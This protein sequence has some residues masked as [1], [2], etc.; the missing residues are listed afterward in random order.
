MKIIK[1]FLLF[2]LVVIL[3]ITG[4]AF[5]I[6]TYYGD[7]IKTLVIDNLNKQLKTEVS[8]R[9]AEF[10]VWENFPQA[11]VVFS[12]VVIYA[13][14]SKNDTLLAAKKLSAQF[15]LI[16]LYHENYKL[17]G[18]GIE[19]GQCKMLTDSEGKPN[20]I[21][22]NESDSSTNTSFS[23]ELEKVSI[24]E[25]EFFYL[26]YSTNIALGFLIEDLGLK[27]NF[28]DA[29]FEMDLKSS[30]KHAN[31]QV[32]ET[33]V[34]SERNLLLKVNGN[35]DQ[36]GE[37]LNFRQ[38]S[39]GIDD[40]TVGVSGQLFYGKESSINVELSSKDTDL[41][42]AIALLPYSLREKLKRFNIK[43]K[44][45]FNG[46]ITGAINS[47]VSPSYS[48]QFLIDNG[49]FKDK[50]SDLKFSNTSLKGSI[51]NG[52][53]K[54]VE[55]TT[56]TLTDFKTQLKNSKLN[57]QLTIENFKQPFYDFTGNLGFELQE[58]IHFLQL[59]EISKPSGSMRAEL[60]M[61]G[62]MSS[63]DEY[64]LKDWKKASVEGKVTLSGVG[65]KYEGHP[66]IVS[67]G[68]GVMSFNNNS[69]N[70][71]KLSVNIDRSQLEI[72][73]KFNNLIG[74]LINNQEALFVDAKLYSPR[75]NLA[76][77]LAS[78][79]KAAKNETT[80]QLQISPRITFYLDT[81]IDELQFNQFNLKT[82]GGNVV[83]KNSGIDA[84]GITFNSQEGQFH[85]DLFIREVRDKLTIAAI[86]DLQ[87]ID[88]Q[89]TF[90]SFNNFGQ[91]TLQSDHISGIANA[92]INFSST[93]SKN[94][95]VDLNSIA[96]DITFNIDKGRLRNF[97]PLES[98]SAFIELDE[99]RDVTF[100][101]L[102]NQI[103]IKES[104]ITI[105]RFNIFS[106]AL[107]VSLAG[108][109]TFENIIDYRVTLLLSEVLGRKAKKSKSYREANSEFG[110][111]EDDGLGKT[112]LFLKMTGSVDQPKIAYDTK[113]L[114]T[115]LQ[116]K[117]SKEKNTFKSIMKE[118][119]GLFKK[120]STVKEL[121]PAKPKKSPFT[122][123]LD[124]SYSKTKNTE[125]KIDRPQDKNEPKNKSKFG[126]FLD[127]IAK[128]NEEEFVV[129]I[130]N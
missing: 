124:S 77:F 125:P 49:L 25:M 129:P 1:R 12:D 53:K 62:R 30:L 48:F 4:A 40:M 80:Y 105:P 91:S 72:E 110:Y 9:A 87:N 31:I 121:P 24:S 50:Q 20:Y 46:T 5:F 52:A 93:W 70:V 18:L 15:N 113:E 88:I 82:L 76:D 3:L 42:K 115:S 116:D 92:T 73:G 112:K 64:T 128:P 51:N 54:T 117:F 35:V 63:I 41:E 66:Q 67:S 10:S 2:I 59:K 126:K 104:K 13:V 122:I 119:F 107:N 101:Q 65:L 11:S 29:V 94:L 27:G 38:A 98:L 71:E 97:K 99:L 111:V 84:R 130:E 45:E 19:S 69:I 28:T 120:D 75:I 127:K 32:D 85:G 7:E 106:S 6:G 58:A 95:E 103:L 22:W 16:D 26:D 109:H 14:N 89:K 23:I 34:L 36:N 114:K 43:G 90:R 55:S 78:E 79:E 17:T 83:V 81:K 74:Y 123:E 108:T 8:I 100:Q 56:L 37:V 102:Q 68:N 47:S 118:E 61:K 33:T 57:G 86:A 60:K 44:A 39:V 96:A 21:F